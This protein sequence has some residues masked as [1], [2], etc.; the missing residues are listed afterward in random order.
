MSFA[1]TLQCENKEGKRGGLTGKLGGEPDER[2]TILIDLQEQKQGE[3]QRMNPRQPSVYTGKGKDITYV[4]TS[5]AL[6]K[7]KKATLSFSVAL[8][9]HHS[10]LCRE[11]KSSYRRKPLFSYCH[12]SSTS[13][14]SEQAIAFWAVQHRC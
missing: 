10:T 4:T 5:Q 13:Y 14:G 2:Y 6:F 9:D 7:E 8:L 12:I 1:A 11:R 3:K